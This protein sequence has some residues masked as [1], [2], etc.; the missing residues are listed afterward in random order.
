MDGLSDFVVEAHRNG[1][2]AT[3]PDVDEE[4]QGKVI[5]YDRDEWEYRDHYYGSDAFIGSEIVI[6]DGRPV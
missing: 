6:F 2:S 4:Q 1:Y 5:T 3:S